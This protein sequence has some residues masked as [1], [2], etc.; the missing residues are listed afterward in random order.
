MERVLKWFGSASRACAIVAGWGLLAISVATC[1]EI[2]GRKYFG[3]SFRSLDEIGGYLLAAVSAF[4]FA[5]ALSKHSHMRVTLLFPY[6]PVGVQ[7]FLNALAMVTLAAMAVFCAWR[8][9][10]EV[11][12]VL[13][14]GKR[15]NTPLSVQ[16]WIPQSI[17]FA[18]MVLFALGSVAMAMQSLALLIRD[19][20]RLNR[21]YGP[22]SLEEEIS[23]EIAH[24]G[25]SEGPGAK[26]APTR[27]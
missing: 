21:I 11:L 7:S 22:L 4:G 13:T 2:L 24:S 17:W 15:S 6:V 19:R 27:T 8:G 9:G 26:G 12:E 1:I 5:Y 3:F 20:P 25:V 18:G 16:L 14:T 23:S 10:A